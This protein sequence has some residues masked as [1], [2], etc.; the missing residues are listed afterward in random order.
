MI[1][2]HERPVNHSEHHAASFL[3]VDR[4]QAEAEDWLDVIYWGVHQNVRLD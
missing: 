1:D 3:S 2:P 4:P